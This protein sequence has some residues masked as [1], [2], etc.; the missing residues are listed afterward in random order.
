MDNKFNVGNPTRENIDYALKNLLFYVTASKQ[1]T[2]YNEQQE[3]F[4]KVLIKIN[5]VFSSYFNGG[6]LKEISEVDLQQVKFD[7]IDLDVETKSMKSYYAEW[8]LMWMEA[9][10][11]L[12]LSEIK[13]GG[14]CNGN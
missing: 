8:S 10:I 4:N 13:Q 7:L 3:L 12:R 1:L 11:S 5:D 14:I 9:I 2:I 6:S